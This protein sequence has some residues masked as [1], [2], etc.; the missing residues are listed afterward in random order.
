LQ[1][2]RA[3]LVRTYAD[4]DDARTK[5]TVATRASQLLYSQSSGEY[6]KLVQALHDRVCGECDR[7][8]TITLLFKDMRLPDGPEWDPK[9]VTRSI[10]AL[11]KALRDDPS[12][13]P[14]PF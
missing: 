14:G 11:C 8:K 3:F 1:L 5:Q 4:P 9:Q 13:F 7:S 6:V 2:L 12:R 10:C